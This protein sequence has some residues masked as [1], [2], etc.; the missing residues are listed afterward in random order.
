M[1]DG[2]FRLFAVFLNEVQHVSFS[3]FKTVLAAAFSELNK[4]RNRQKLNK[5]A[6]GFIWKLTGV[7]QVADKMREA[8]RWHDWDNMVD[9]Q[10]SESLFLYPF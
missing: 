3:V 8:R 9:V 4:Q 5:E 10:V 1:A 7:Q 2:I 6:P